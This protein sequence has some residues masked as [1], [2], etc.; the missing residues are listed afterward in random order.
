MMQYDRLFGLIPAIFKTSTVLSQT[1]WRFYDLA[2]VATAK[3]DDNP[4]KM[5][6]STRIVVL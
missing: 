3:I 1:C 6:E 5:L 2:P 4:L